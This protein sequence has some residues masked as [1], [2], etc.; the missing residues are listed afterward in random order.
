MLPQQAVQDLFRVE[1]L[2]PQGFEVYATDTHDP[3]TQSLGSKTSIV[4]AWG[5]CFLTAQCRA[6]FDLPISAY[7]ACHVIINDTR[8]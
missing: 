8:P 3:R 7:T 2:K 6:A 4:A 1:E 5:V